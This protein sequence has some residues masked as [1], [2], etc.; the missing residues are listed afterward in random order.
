MTNGE[1]HADAIRGI[2]AE[3]ERNTIDRVVKIIDKTIRAASLSG[4]N[5]NLTVLGTLLEVKDKVLGLR[6]EE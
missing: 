3:T 6:G 2:V 4:I 1:F 5:R